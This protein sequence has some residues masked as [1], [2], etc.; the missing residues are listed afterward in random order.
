MAREFSTVGV[1]GLG[2]MGAGIAEVLARTGLTVKAV[3]VDDGRVSRAGSG[4][5]STRRTAR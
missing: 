5:S 4:T 3:D 2:T 1:V